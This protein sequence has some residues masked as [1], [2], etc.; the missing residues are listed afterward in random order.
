MSACACMGPAGDCPCIR[1]SKGL[2]VPITETYAFPGYWNFLTDAEKNTINELK[3]IAVMRS[4]FEKHPQ[5]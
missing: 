2:S 4:V 5:V 3:L 1:R